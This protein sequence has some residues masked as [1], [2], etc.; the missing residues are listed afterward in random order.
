MRPRRH[1]ALLGGPSTSPLAAMSNRSGR[2]G[3]VWLITV[4]YALMFALIALVG[5]Y[6]LSHWEA[7]PETAKTQLRA[8][9]RLTWVLMAMGYPLSLVAIV[10][11]FRLRRSSLYLYALAFAFGIAASLPSYLMAGI[12]VNQLV[13]LL[14]QVLVGLY[15][16]RLLRANV[17]R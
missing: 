12:T 17:L 2:P 4:L 15:I 7:L 11:L 5:W 1:G 14:V 8:I 3:L 9:P 13:G 10:Q 16:W 6:S